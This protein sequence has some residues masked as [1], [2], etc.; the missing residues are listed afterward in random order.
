MSDLRS[1][2]DGVWFLMWLTHYEWYSSYVSVTIGRR[3]Q[4]G[5]GGVLGY[6]T[7]RQS[8]PQIIARLADNTMDRF[9]M[10]QDDD[11][12]SKI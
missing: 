11:S 4:T 7:G 12:R 2:D 8:L 3:K 5:L 1:D 9:K 10:I 6:L